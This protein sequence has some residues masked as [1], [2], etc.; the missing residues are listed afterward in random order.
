MSELYGC[1]LFK[2]LFGAYVTSDLIIS[3]EKYLDCET[4]EELR[5]CIE[6]DLH[7]ALYL[8]DIEWDTSETEI[9]IP[10]EFIVNW[11]KLKENGASRTI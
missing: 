1:T 7:D 6:S 11:K 5:D 4:E 2:K 9:T 3:P 10:N 8:G